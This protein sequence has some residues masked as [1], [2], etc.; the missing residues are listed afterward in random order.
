MIKKQ[1]SNLLKD[2][3]TKDKSIDDKIDNLLNQVKR[4]RQDIVEINKKAE[5]RTSE[6]EV[7]FNNSISKIEKHFDDLDRAEKEFDNEIDKIILEQ[8]E[9]LA[10]EE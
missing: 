2:N 5:K 9:D 6:L 1:I 3:K 7:R 10:E 8:A 4:I